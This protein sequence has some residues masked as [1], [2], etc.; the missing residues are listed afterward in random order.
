MAAVD[1]FLKIEGIDGESTDD[2]HKGEIE[3]SSWSWGQSNTGALHGGGGGAGKVQMQDF[4]FVMDVSQASPALFLACASGQHIKAALLTVR[5]AGSEDRLEFYKV[6]FTDCFVS[7]YNA[8]G[9]TGGATPTPS[10]STTGL[11]APGGGGGTGVPSESVSL[12]F[13]KIEVSYQRR[14]PDGTLADAAKAGWDLA[15]NKKA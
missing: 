2:L 3:I 7:S 8:A 11:A 12:N 9:D 10:P 14:L 5:K 4:H 1:Y 6:R 15:A 13:R